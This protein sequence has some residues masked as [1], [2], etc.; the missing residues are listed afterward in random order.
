MRL[1]V[2]CVSDGGF[3]D[4]PAQAVR[5]L[6]VLNGRAAVDQQRRRADHDGQRPRARDR[7]VKALTVKDKAH[8][9]R[10]VFWA[11]RRYREEHDVRL[12]PLELVHCSDLD[13]LQ[14]AISEDAT[15]AAHLRV[16]RRYDDDIGCNG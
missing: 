15:E 10:R 5:D 1:L 6:N 16:I 12:T 2:I 13:V 8:P 7:H 4:E 14:A 11:R 3:F 9:T